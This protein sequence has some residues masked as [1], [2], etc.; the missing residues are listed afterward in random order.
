MFPNFPKF[1]AMHQLGHYILS[2]GISV[3]PLQ[4]T[5]RTDM[6]PVNTQLY[7]SNY[8]G[9]YMC[10]LHS[11]HHQ[12]LYVRRIKGNHIPVVYI[13]LKMITGIYLD[14]TYKGI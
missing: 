12:A 8:K 6:W 2:C 14:L 10:Q 11:S 9:R 7:C 4:Y 3:V 1:Q 5:V 13:Y